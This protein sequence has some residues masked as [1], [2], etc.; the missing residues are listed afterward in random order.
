[1]RISCCCLTSFLDRCHAVLHGDD[2]VAVPVL[3]EHLFTKTARGGA[4]SLIAFGQT[5][6][7]K[8]HTL[9]AVLRQLPAAL[10]REGAILVTVSSVELRGTQAYDLLSLMSPVK[11]LEDRTGEV[12]LRGASSHEASSAEEL[13]S[14]LTQSMANRTVAGTERNEESSRFADSTF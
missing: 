12:H 11:I 1:M 6:T 3:G 10:F 13:S 5:G 14:L 7:G 4:G 8:T 2:S 9:N